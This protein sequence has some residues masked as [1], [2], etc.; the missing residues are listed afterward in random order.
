MTKKPIAWEVTDAKSLVTEAL[1]LSY[2]HPDEEGVT[3]IPAVFQ[4]GGDSRLIVVVGENASGKSFVR[5]IFSSICSQIK[6]E[7][8]PISMEGRGAPM[9]GIRGFIYGSE[10]YDSTG[11]NSSRTVTTGIRTCKGRENR[12]VIIWDEPDLGLSDAGAAGMGQ[13]TAYAKEPSEH[14]LAMVVITHS[15]PLVRELLALGPHY[16]HVGA[17]KPEEAP[18]TLDAWLSQTLPAR[19]PDDIIATG[20]ARYRRIQPILNQK[21]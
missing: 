15:K 19:S 12:H 3:P 11:V 9:G 21:E 10:E 7:A 14:T 18:A 17:D 4:P 2:F 20:L 16:L 1:S 5:R 13:A 8:M 6:I